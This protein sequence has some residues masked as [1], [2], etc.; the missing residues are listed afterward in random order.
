[1]TAILH[2]S[3]HGA[4]H[5]AAGYIYEYCSHKSV[6]SFLYIAEGYIVYT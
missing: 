1:M 6:V 2:A 5:F 4:E 3:C